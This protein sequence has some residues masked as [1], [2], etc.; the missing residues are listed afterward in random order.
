M[1]NFPFFLRCRDRWV[2]FPYTI[3]E[4][5]LARHLQLFLSKEEGIIIT[6]KGA[7]ELLVSYG[8]TFQEAFVEVAGRYIGRCECECHIET[9]ILHFDACCRFCTKCKQ[10]ILYSY[11]DNHHCT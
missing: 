3:E 11:Y 4:G 5:K 10:G 8:M 9:G 7:L 1:T 6:F 2:G